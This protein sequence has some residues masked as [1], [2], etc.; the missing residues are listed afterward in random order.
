MQMFLMCVFFLEL[1]EEDEAPVTWYFSLLSAWVA[2]SSGQ[3]LLG[4]C[5]RASASTSTRMVQKA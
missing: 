4:L 5:L 1:F 3:G 2:S